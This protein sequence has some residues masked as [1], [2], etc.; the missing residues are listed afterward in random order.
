MVRDDAGKICEKSMGGVGETEWYREGNG[1]ASFE[2]AECICLV[3]VV[4]DAYF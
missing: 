1:L 3:V 4:V 2:I